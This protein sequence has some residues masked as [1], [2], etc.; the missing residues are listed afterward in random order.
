VRHL[1][2]RF[3]PAARAW[4]CERLARDA[5]GRLQ[6]VAMI[7]PGALLFCSALEK[8]GEPFVGITHKLLAG[9]E[10]GL[11]IDRLLLRGAN[12]FLLLLR[13]ESRRQSVRLGAPSFASPSPEDRPSPSTEAARLR[14][15]IRR[16]APHVAP[17]DVCGP[18]PPAF[19]PE[20][21]PR[22]RACARWYATLRVVTDLAE[23]RVLP[24]SAWSFLSRR[25]VELA[26]IAIHIGGP[27]C[28]REVA[29]EEGRCLGGVALDWC[30]EACRWPGRNTN[31]GRF[32]EALVAWWEDGM[33]SA[34]PPFPTS[35]P[36]VEG[37][38]LAPILTGSQLR[39]AATRLQN[40][41]AGYRRRLDGE[42]CWVF[43]GTLASGD[44]AAFVQLTGGRFVVSQVYGP[45]NEP[46]SEQ[47]RSLLRRW[48]QELNRAQVKSLEKL[49]DHI[50]AQLPLG[51]T[52]CSGDRW[53][54]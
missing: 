27:S 42:R 16:A 13:H 11:P 43:V 30:E 39:E 12:D 28:S 1:T 29:R 50:G 3:H 37:A 36:E 40:C 8:R 10:T 20:D 54:P 26:D 35:T 18:P 14:I 7:C 32:V 53:E 5:S 22:G 25:A 44:V 46:I 9:V 19:A 24:A 41:L 49:G 38:K 47:Q 51:L 4:V 52:P 21:I 48:L 23:G 6:D 33:A 31:V 34:L 45:K 2:R 15:L 17:E